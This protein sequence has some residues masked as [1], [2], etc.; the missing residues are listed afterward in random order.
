MPA[1]K[2]TKSRT[3]IIS[4]TVG[5]KYIEAKQ[6][7]RKTSQ[8]LPTSI[9]DILSIKC[10]LMNE[11]SGIHLFTVLFLSRIPI[12]KRVFKMCINICTRIFAVLHHCVC[13]IVSFSNEICQLLPKRKNIKETQYSPDNFFLF[14]HL[15]CF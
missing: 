7:R 14:I 13:Y 12:F 9:S 11:M 4:K 10:Q 2:I 6:K 5:E 1:C 15:S 3:S 8:I